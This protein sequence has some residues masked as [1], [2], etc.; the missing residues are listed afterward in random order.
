MLPTP[1]L[2][3]ASAA[4]MLAAAVVRAA[5]PLYEKHVIIFIFDLTLAG[6]W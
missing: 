2:I 6:Y 3:D 5:P 1:G 4:E